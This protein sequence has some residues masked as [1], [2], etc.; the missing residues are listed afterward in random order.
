MKFLEQMWEMPLLAPIGRPTMAVTRCYR[1]D[2]RGRPMMYDEECPRSSAKLGDVA[3][4]W[5]FYA[6]LVLVLALV[7]VTD[8]SYR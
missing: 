2:M 8:I 4:G 1:T 5:I 7:T 3:A 6:A